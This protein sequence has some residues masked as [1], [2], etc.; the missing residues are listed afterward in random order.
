M[1]PV[2]PA[3]APREISGI[4][5]VADLRAVFV[6]SPRYKRAGI[7]VFF[8][9]ESE[10]TLAVRP[11]RIEVPD[12]ELADLN[13]RLARYRAA[14]EPAGG[15]V[16]SAA[17]RTRRSYSSGLLCFSPV[18]PCGSPRWSRDRAGTRPSTHRR[19]AVE[20]FIGCYFGRRNGR[21]GPA[22]SPAGFSSFVAEHGEFVRRGARSLDPHRGDSRLTERYFAGGWGDSPGSRAI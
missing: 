4:A 21:S 17:S 5:Y 7:S 10:L 8:Q 19:A 16:W 20:A 6:G 11:C 3:I 18:P 22:C 14:P 15:D 2:I 12:Q 9:Q 13:E 1:L